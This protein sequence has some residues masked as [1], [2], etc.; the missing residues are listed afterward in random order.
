M[1]LAIRC[2]RPGC[3]D[4]DTVV[5]DQPPPAERIAQTVLSGLCLTTDVGGNVHL[6]GV[7]FLRQPCDLGG[8]ITAT[9]H[10]RGA[11]LAQSRV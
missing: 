9:Q 10:E 3:H 2:D 1:I 6:C 5:R 11:Q 8:D 7:H 4:G